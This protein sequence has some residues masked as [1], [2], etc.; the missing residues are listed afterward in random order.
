MGEFYFAAYILPTLGELGL[1]LEGLRR[2]FA[3]YYD[4]ASC[5]NNLEHS[6]G[7]G[8]RFVQH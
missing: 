3:A 5:K 1:D 7:C 8:T 4:E 6:H 2:M